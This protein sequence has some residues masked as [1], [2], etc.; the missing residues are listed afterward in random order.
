VWPDRNTVRLKNYNANPLPQ[1][2]GFWNNC[3]VVHARHVYALQNITDQQD[4]LTA[5]A[6]ER[7]V[8]IFNGER[9]L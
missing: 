5:L 9:W 7:R 8:V 1:A 2:E 6:D 3:P 4:E